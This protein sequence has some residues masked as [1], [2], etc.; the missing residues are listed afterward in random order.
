MLIWAVDAQDPLQSLDPE[1]QQGAAHLVLACCVMPASQGLVAPW[2]GLCG[3]CS[4]RKVS[5][6]LFS[7]SL[8]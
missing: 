3:Q 1:Q 8:A 5:R 2:P 4:A 7:Q 6:D